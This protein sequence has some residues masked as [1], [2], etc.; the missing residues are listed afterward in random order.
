M[1]PLNTT[2]LPLAAAFIGLAAVLSAAPASA[3]GLGILTTGGFHTTPVYFYDASNNLAQIK[4]SQ[5]IF[6]GGAGFDLTL[7]DPDDRIVGG[8]RG[9][10]LMDSAE[11]DP[12]LT[13]STVAAN[14]VVANWRDDP[15]HIGVASV[16]VIAGIIGDPDTFQLTGSI[17]IGSGF[18]T[19]DHREFLLAEAG[20]GATWNFAPGVQAFG[21]LQYALR[22]H[23]GFKHGANG[24][25]GARYMFD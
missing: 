7:G 9:Y 24:V 13:T 11:Q 22:Q 14:D 17:Y 6:S 5:T 15:A 10:W 19:T 3:G 20:V 8:F 25:L 18:L 12:A 16:G 4:Q 1:R 2:A 21:T 23:K